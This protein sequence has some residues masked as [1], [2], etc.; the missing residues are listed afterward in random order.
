MKDPGLD[1]DTAERMLRG[2]RT[3]PHP[4]ADLL[5]AAAEPTREELSGEDTAAAAFVAARSAPGRRRRRTRPSVSFVLK[6]AAAL[7]VLLAGGVTVA[8]AARHLPGPLGGDHPRHVRTPR[9]QPG[10]SRTPSRTSSHAAGGRSR[11]HRAHGIRPTDP[12]RSET[13]K[14]F[15]GPRSKVEGPH[16]HVHTKKLP[17]PKLHR[18]DPKSVP[19]PPLDVR[20]SADV[21]AR[22]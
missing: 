15:P 1:P 20:P 9:T 22:R 7:L 10:R 17:V 19:L 16:P 18:P 11:E 4:L 12:G 8:T 2:E 13:S 3:R 14:A 6:V 21:S 5:A